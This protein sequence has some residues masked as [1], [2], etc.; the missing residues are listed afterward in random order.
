MK[1]KKMLVGMLLL[2]LGAHWSL[3]AKDIRKGSEQKPESK[4]HSDIKLKGKK[5]LQNSP[6]E[7]GGMDYTQTKNDAD[8]KSRLKKEAAKVLGKDQGLRQSQINTSALTEKLPKK[9]ER[10]KDVAQKVSK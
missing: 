8:K 1:A 7:Q 3:S 9:A 4:A 6:V 10:D 5:I 2:S